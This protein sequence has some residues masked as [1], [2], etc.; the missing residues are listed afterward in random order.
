MKLRAVCGFRL[1]EHFAI[2]LGRSGSLATH[3]EPNGGVRYAKVKALKNLVISSVPAIGYFSSYSSLQ[4]CELL[5]LVFF[6]HLFYMVL[7]FNAT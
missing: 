3:E 1:I 4:L 5:S 2:R 7:F 6:M